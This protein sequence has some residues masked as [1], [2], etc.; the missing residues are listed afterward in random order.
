ME[1][2][3]TGLG[4]ARGRRAYIFREVKFRLR[5]PVGLTLHCNSVAFLDWI[6]V[7]ESKH[8]FLRGI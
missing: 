3:Y 8:R 2:Q 6:S 5:V 4:P 7:G 1:K